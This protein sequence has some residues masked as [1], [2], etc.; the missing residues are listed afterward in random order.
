MKAVFWDNHYFSSDFHKFFSTSDWFITNNLNDFV[1]FD[2]SYKLSMIGKYTE[3]HHSK[4]YIRDIL[5]VSDKVIVFDSELHNKHLIPILEI[6]DPKLTWVIPGEVYGINNTIF[7]N[8]WLRGQIEMYRQPQIR[9]DL[10]ELDP[11]SI[12]PYFFDALL[13]G[14]KPHKD[15]VAK[16]IREDELDKKILLRHAY[17]DFILPQTITAGHG[18][19]LAN[20]KGWGCLL[21]T[22]VPINIYNQSAYSIIGETE[23]CNTHFF[24]TEKTAKCLISKRLF[25]MF[26]GA[27]WLKTFRKLGFKTFNGII[28][29]SYDSI[30]DSFLRWEAAYQQVKWLCDQDQHT[31]LE[32]ARPILEYNYNHLW[33]TDWREILN[34]RVLAE[35]NFD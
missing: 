31:I 15:Y 17:K 25:V 6:T 8:Q 7:N 10:D 35:I 33:T 14:G 13:G 23:F 34:Q 1:N 32:K 26:S 12:K 28:D 24:L 20:Y 27:N 9:V 30:N 4:K 16:R 5:A 19:S 11:Y 3:G 21:S 22:I 29:E 18:A 2:S